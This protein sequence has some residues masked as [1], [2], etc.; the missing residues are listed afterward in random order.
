MAT[1]HLEMTGDA[2]RNG[3]VEVWIDQLLLKPILTCYEWFTVKSFRIAFRL[4]YK[5]IWDLAAETGRIS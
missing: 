2:D 4:F 5:E 1:E 3:G